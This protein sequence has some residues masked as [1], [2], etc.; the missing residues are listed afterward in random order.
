MKTIENTLKAFALLTL[1]GAL[2]FLS[3][4]NKN[5][6]TSN[7]RVRMTDAPG[8]FQEVNV[9]VIR[10]EVH[11]EKDG[12][13]ALETNAGIYD[14]LLLQNNVTAVLVNEGEVPVGKISQF[15]L[16]LGGDNSVMVDSVYYSL[17][18]PS[19]EQSGL[20]MNVNHDFKSD[21][22]YDIL[23]DFDAEKSIVKKGNG[24]YSLKPVLR[25]EG[26]VEL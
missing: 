4:C 22:T 19:A 18:T 20:K 15:R 24:G 25:V 9:E 11:Y 12:W 6:G 3:S 10:A 8:D 17:D 7:L 16:I 1:T 14:L 23:I 26:I 13:V 2:M 5:N 21:K